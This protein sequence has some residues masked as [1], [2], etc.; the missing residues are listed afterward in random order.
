MRIAYVCT[1]PGVPVFGRKG[2][3]VHVQEL[4]RALTGL[5]HELTLFAARTG[6]DVASDLRSTRVVALAAVR[7]DDA[8]TRE[9]SAMASADAAHG[10]LAAAGGFDLVYERYALWGGA[11]MR[12]ARALGV[13]GVLEVNAPLVDE[14]ATHRGLVH[15]DEAEA[16]ERSALAAASLI[17]AV[18]SE[19]AAYLA[20]FPEAVGKVVVVPNGVDP[21]RFEPREPQPSDRY[22]VGFVGT[23]KAW[24]GLDTLAE[25][26]AQL[27]AERDDVELLVVGDGPQRASLETTLGRLDVRA[28]ATLTGAVTPAEVAEHLAAMD[29]AVAPYPPLEGFYFSPLKVFE[30]LAAGVPVVAS[31]IGQLD[32]LLR[33]RDTCLFAEPGSAASLAA[34]LGR[35]LGDLGL[36]RRLARN[37]RAL[38]EREHTWRHVAHTIL[39]RARA[40]TVRS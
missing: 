9:R 21:R 30:Y 36:R 10:V 35:A 11:G 1:D 24:H 22:T 5:G 7:G 12:H 27:R 3:S 40:E 6:D 28:A 20:R 17:V 15:R 31:R 23:L 33:E 39:D 29:V 14:H 37:G 8:R 34:A 19:V 26:F 18:S 38:V 32:A 2:A 25:A 13:P 4:V 16:A